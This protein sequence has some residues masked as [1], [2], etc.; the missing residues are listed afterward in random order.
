MTDLAV[1]SHVILSHLSGESEF[2]GGS[3][4]SGKK[5]GNATMWFI[6]C[7]KYKYFLY[8]IFSAQI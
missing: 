3:L 8:Y 7:F 5:K 4:V 1:K 2:V 6:F